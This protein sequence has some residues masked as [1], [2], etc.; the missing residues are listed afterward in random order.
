VH[1]NFVLCQGRQKFVPLLDKS[2]VRPSH[3]MGIDYWQTFS[4][5]IMIRFQEIAAADV[6][7]KQTS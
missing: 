5:E 2:G 6:P 1:Q 3:S 7:A 4:S